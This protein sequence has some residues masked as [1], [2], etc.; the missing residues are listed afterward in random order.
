MSRRLASLAL[1]A[2]MT[3]GACAPRYQ[4]TDYA[5][6][7][8]EGPYQLASGDKL[9]IIVFGQD[10]LSNIYAV[11]GSGKISMPLVNTIVAQGRSTQQLA[12]EIEA[13]LRG[14]YLR[15]PKVSVEVDTYRPF[16]VLGE[17]TNSGQFPFVSGMTV[18]TAVA[19]AG[20]FTPRGQRNSA[21]VTRQIEGQLVTATVP[22][23]YPVQP[24]DTIVIKER[25]F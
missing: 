10:N 4:A 23:T 14:G 18:Q 7:Q 8:P 22:I 19:I 9:R 3:V 17:V 24:G 25:W 13:K 11:D 5:L 16:F 21:E 6:A 15:E 12:R 20:G 1:A 2:A